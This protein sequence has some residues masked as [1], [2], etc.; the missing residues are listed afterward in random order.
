[1]VINK[2]KCEDRNFSQKHKQLEFYGESLPVGCLMD[3]DKFSSVN[4]IRHVKI[5][6][7]RFSPLNKSSRRLLI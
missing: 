2:M 5:K 3:A 4:S 1:M 6:G 7:A